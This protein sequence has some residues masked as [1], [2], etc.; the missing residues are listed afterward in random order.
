VDALIQ[1]INLDVRG[2]AIKGLLSEDEAN[3]VST[4]LEKI[5]NPSI[6]GIIKFLGEKGSFSE[7]GTT[8]DARKSI[9]VSI[10]MLK[11]L[12]RIDGDKGIVELRLQKALK[13]E[14][15]AQK[16]ARLQMAIGDLEKTTF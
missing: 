7:S 15:D 4:S 3:P 13:E 16:Q 11:T 8:F 10:L 12:C 9:D 14:T 1:N 2:R 6:Q 5:G